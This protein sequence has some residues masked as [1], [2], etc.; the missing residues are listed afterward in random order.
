MATKK[1]NENNSGR[2]PEENMTTLDDKTKVLIGLGVTEPTPAEECPLDEKLAAFVDG[3]LRRKERKVILEHLDACSSCYRQWLDISSIRQEEPVKST[4]VFQ[5]V[6]KR[7]YWS[8]GFAL[9]VAACLM[10]V[11]WRT[12][13]Y[14]PEM[15]NMLALSYE[16]AL[17]GE[18]N[19]KNIEP[20]KIPKLPWEKETTRGQF[21]KP[22][23]TASLAFAAGF[24]GGR[25][26]LAEIKGKVHK[27]VEEW[28]TTQWAPY[29]YLGRWCILL[30]S[31]C[32]SGYVVPSSFWKQQNE[33]PDM[34]EKEFVRQVDAG[35]EFEIAIVKKALKRI[36]HILEDNQT[37]G[38][39][40]QLIEPELEAIKA[41][42]S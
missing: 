9:A 6:K 28:D 1:D 32:Q 39:I 14:S 21:S 13:L 41:T 35:E 11:M 8:S 26:E 38:N 29:F 17:K 31:V 4:P 33:I 23:S 2:Q 27:G 20:G 25:S 16:T 18:M 12:F 24:R 22:E 34:M 42:L 15:A 3:R 10:L 40:C 5:V 19:L 7:M 36:K 37:D 30:Q